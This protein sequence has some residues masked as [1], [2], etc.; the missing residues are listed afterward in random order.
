MLLPR[1]HGPSRMRPVLGGSATDAAGT[2][3]RAASAVVLAYADVSAFGAE[4]LC[5]QQARSS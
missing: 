3:R 5:V 2:A 4:L 1:R